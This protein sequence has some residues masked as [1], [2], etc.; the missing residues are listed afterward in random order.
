MFDSANDVKRDFVTKQ[1]RE[2][3]FHE[4]QSVQEVTCECGCSMPL[5]FAYRCLYCG[6]F[7][8]LV[9]AEIHF[10]MTR[11]EWLEKK[12]NQNDSGALECLD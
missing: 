10:G 9:C 4:G 2:A 3:M 1:F 12:E 6:Q 7:Y 5:R 11:K 8:C